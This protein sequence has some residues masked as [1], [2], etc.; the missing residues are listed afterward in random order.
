MSAPALSVVVASLGDAGLDVA[1]ESVRV[2]AAAG[3]VDAEVVVA[4][5][6]AGDAPRL[7]DGVR[8]V[9]VFPFG[10]SHARNRG[11]AA[12][13]APVV[14]FVDDD[15]VVEEGWAAAVLDAFTRSPRPAGVFGPIAALGEGLAYNQRGA[16]E[17]RTFSGPATPPW[18]VGSGGNMAFDREAIVGVG[19][20]DM[21]FGAGAVA[22]SAE[23]TELMVRLFRAGQTL[24]WQPGMVVLHPTKTEVERFAA[25]FPYGYGVGKLV[26]R[27]RD[28]TLAAKYLKASGQAITKA[29]RTRDRRRRRESLATLR[30]FLSGAVLPVDVRSP[31]R[32]LSRA[33]AEIADLLH[34]ERLRPL[35]PVLHSTPHLLYHVGGDRLLHV[36]VDPSRELVGS[37]GRR[38]RIRASGVDGIPDVVASAHGRDSLWLLEE[39]IPGRHPDPARREQWLDAVADWAVTLAGSPGPPLR[40]SSRWRDERARLAADGRL[41]ESLDVVD[42]LPSVHVHGDLQRKNV[43]LDGGRVGVIDWAGCELDGL[44]GRDL[45][46]LATMAAGDSPDGGVAQA[47]VAGGDAYGLRDRLARVG[48]GPA[49]LPHVVLAVT[50]L[51]ALHEDERHAAPGTRRGERAYRRVFDGVARVYSVRRP[52]P[53]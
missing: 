8:I 28:A 18:I 1:V 25:R 46:F 7:G 50:A 38:E 27:H 2:S 36:Y 21:L 42:G 39:R 9:D 4:W 15:E 44:P 23:E 35:E 22:R 30:G 49:E 33:P 47:L 3:G 17:A 45:L 19:G 14:A 6:G 10:L 13:R 40:E 24:A 16:G 43:L 5:Q 31:E 29:V 48:V 20:F 11:L 51:W 52:T 53:R 41:A 26:R 37:P 32:A 12:A 34:G